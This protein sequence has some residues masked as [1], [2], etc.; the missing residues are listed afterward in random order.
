MHAIISSDLL[1]STHA[2]P[3]ARLVFMVLQ[4][5]VFESMCYTVSVA[6]HDAVGMLIVVAPLFRITQADKRLDLFFVPHAFH[7]WNVFK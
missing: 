3:A 1:S 6:L 2:K 7:A 4:C 5:L